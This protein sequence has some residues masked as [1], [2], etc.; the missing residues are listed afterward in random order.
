MLNFKDVGFVGSLKKPLADIV[1]DNAGNATGNST[2]ITISNFAVGNGSNRILL[3]TVMTNNFASST[4]VTF[5][6]ISLTLL[7]SYQPATGNWGTVAG[8]K[9]F[10]LL[11]PPNVTANIVITSGTST[12]LWASAASY[13]GVAQTSTFGTVNKVRKGATSPINFSVTTE[14]NKSAIIMV[15]SQD[16]TTSAAISYTS[17]QTKRSD[18]SA[19]GGNAAIG[20]AVYATA[21]AQSPQATWTGGVNVDVAGMAVEMK[22]A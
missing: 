3:V 5:N 22:A 8:M 10:Y 6:N 4:T 17:P 21:G 11:D 14:Q 16:S 15:V 2:S 7:D 1:F 12:F 19:N 18:V 9:L 13:S 20:E